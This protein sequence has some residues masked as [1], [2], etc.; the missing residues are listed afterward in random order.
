MTEEIQSNGSRKY[1]INYMMLKRTRDTIQLISKI[2][3]KSEG[4]HTNDF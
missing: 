1:F 4:T 2:F 3:F